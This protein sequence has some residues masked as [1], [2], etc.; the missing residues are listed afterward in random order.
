MNRTVQDGSLT[1]VTSYDQNF[2]ITGTEVQKAYENVSTF[3]EMDDKFKAAWEQ[4]T[5]YLPASWAS[6]AIQFAQEGNQILVIATADDPSDAAAFVNGD[7]IGRITDW[8]A[9]DTWTRWFDDTEVDVESS[10]W[11]YNYHLE[12][13]TYIANSGGRE[14]E[15]INLTDDDGNPVAN[16]L[17]EVGQHVSAVAHKFNMSADEWA[18]LQSEVGASDDLLTRLGTD[19]N[20]VNYIQVQDNNWSAVENDYRDADDLYADGEERIE[21]HGFASPGSTDTVFL[22]AITKREG[23]IVLRDEQWNEVAR[24]MDPSASSEDTSYDAMVEKYGETFSGMWQA[25]ETVLPATLSSSRGFALCR[26]S[27]Q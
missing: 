22:G 15:L 16:Q 7:V 10:G 9:T 27:A 11:S 3:D 2:N 25:L 20:S 6:G 24:L 5:D 14:V 8:N 18:A 1:I 19:W 21:L 12:D 17:D 23:F 13:W 4:A 26:R